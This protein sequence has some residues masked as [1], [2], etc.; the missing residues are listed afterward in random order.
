MWGLKRFKIHYGK[1]PDVFKFIAASYNK[2]K[3]AAI[4]FPYIILNFEKQL[5]NL[6]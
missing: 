2:I 4:R 3:V 1:S 6:Q 5:Q